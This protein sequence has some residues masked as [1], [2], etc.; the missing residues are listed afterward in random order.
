MISVGCDIEAIA[1]FR[2]VLD[3]EGF[4]NNVFT[5]GEI[6]GSMKKPEPEASL[7]RKF[8]GKEAV[9]KALSSLGENVPLKMIEIPDAENPK[10]YAKILRNKVSGK[11]N[12]FVSIASTKDTVFA[13]SVAE[14]IKR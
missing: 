6:E 11:Y 3:N 5:Q 7:A 12:V 10:T 4:L 2:E 13:S 8:A 14:R 1:R 9:F